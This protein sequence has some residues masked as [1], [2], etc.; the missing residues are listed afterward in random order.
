MP[1][2]AEKRH[3]PFSPERLYNLVADIERYPDF[4]P[5]C[6]AARVRNREGNVLM[7]DLVIGFKMI[8]ERYT[9]RVTLGDGRIEVVYTEG[10]FKYLNNHWIFTPSGDG[11]TTIEFYIDFEFRSKLLKAV[12]GALFNEAVGLM[13]GA[14]E[15]RARQLYGTGGRLAGHAG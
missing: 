9:S 7:A 11:G 3:L 6:I 4:L 2:H 5:W 14:F 15:R 12:M 8:R 10:P 1:T 13:V